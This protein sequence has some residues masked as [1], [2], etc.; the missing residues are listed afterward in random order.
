MICSCFV[1]L[2]YENIQHPIRFAISDLLPVSNTTTPILISGYRFICMQL[3]CAGWLQQINFILPA[4]LFGIAIYAG[5]ALYLFFTEDGVLDWI[6]KHNA[7][8]IAGT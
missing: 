7:E 5:Y 2:T 4:Y 3:F 6:Q 1:C 8:N